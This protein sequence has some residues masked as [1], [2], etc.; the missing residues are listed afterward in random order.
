MSSSYFGPRL[1][2]VLE[3]RTIP[4]RQ[5][6]ELAGVDRTLLNRYISGDVRPSREVL[7]KLCRAL[8]EELDRAEI[9]CAHLR[10]ETPPSAEEL[11]QIVNLVTDPDL[12]MR[13]DSGQWAGHPLPKKAQADFD[14]L[15]SLAAGNPDILD[16][17]RATLDVIQPRKPSLSQSQRQ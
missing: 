12:R 15:R 11:I 2:L 16:W 7:E 17:I 10:D 6:A 4:Q 5:F 13:E 14:A 8:P 9:V 1:Q 3:R